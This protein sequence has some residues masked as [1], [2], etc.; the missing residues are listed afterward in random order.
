[1]SFWRQSTS[2]S[3]DLHKGGREWTGRDGR[4]GTDGADWTGRTGLDGLE[5]IGEEILL[6][7]F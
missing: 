3:L 4:G 2:R 6:E 7:C 1:M 5:D